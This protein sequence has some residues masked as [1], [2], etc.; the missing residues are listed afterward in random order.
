MSLN[1]VISID[2][3]G[4]NLR[5]GIVDESLNILTQIKEKSIHDDSKL[6]YL[7]IKKM[8]N[9]VLSSSFSSNV[10]KI[11]ICCAGFINN[12]RIEKSPNLN[13]N[14]FD[15]IPLLQE[16]FPFIK[17]I[18]IVNDANSEAYMEAKFGA[19]SKYS[20]S[21]FLTISTGIGI[22]VINNKQLIDL[23]F[24]VGHNYINYKN[25]FYEFEQLCSGNGIVLL[26]KLNNLIVKN[27]QEF[28]NLVSNKNELALKI[29]ETWLQLLGSQIAN[30]QLNYNSD[31]IVISGGVLLSKDIFLDDLEKI[32]NTFIASYPCKK[33]KFVEAKFNQDTGLISGASLVL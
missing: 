15:L 28:F 20:N 18:S 23:P 31:V 9:K 29:Y 14:N 2:L 32:T 21:I 24:E 1:K 4:T 10:N 8:V 3:G 6:L 33:V 11:G 13:I 26:C 7:Q 12:G 30:M 5:V 27:S 22:G 19:A 25:K 17:E 16:D